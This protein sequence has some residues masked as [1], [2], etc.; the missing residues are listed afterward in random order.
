[1]YYSKLKKLTQ[2]NIPVNLFADNGLKEVPDEQVNPYW[3]DHHPE[4]K[5]GA[6]EFLPSNEVQFWKDLIER[7]LFVLIKDVNVSAIIS[8]VHFPTLNMPFF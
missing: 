4:M 2:N 8:G 3:I 6:V 7:Y 5:K 1:M